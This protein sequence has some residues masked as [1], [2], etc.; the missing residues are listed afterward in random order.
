MSPQII[1]TGFKWYVAVEKWE[2]G[3]MT[4]AETRW[5]CF[6]PDLTRLAS[7]TSITNL[8]V[9]HIAIVARKCKHL[10]KKRCSA[11]P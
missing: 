10:P 8:P 3:Q 7:G 4:R 5:G 9:D 2:A 6:L 1:S 11:A